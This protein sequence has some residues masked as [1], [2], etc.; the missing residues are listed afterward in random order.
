MACRVS[1]S[2]LACLRSGVQQ[3]QRVEGDLALLVGR[4]DHDARAALSLDFAGDTTSAAGV[5]F[6]I[7]LEAEQLEVLQGALAYGRGVLADAA[8]EGRGLRSLAGTACSS[9]HHGLTN[10]AMADDVHPERDQE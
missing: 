2:L 7:E 10:E 9:T 3:G 1:L 6:G 5:G 4:H 8:G